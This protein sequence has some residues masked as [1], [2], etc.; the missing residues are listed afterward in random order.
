MDPGKISF[1]VVVSGGRELW[2]KHEVVEFTSQAL[3]IYLYI[4]R[5]HMAYGVVYRRIRKGK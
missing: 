3:T 2:H 1:K 4:Y 5:V